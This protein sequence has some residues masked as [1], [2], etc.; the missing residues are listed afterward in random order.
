MVP[1]VSVRYF[2]DQVGPAVTESHPLTVEHVHLSASH[3]VFG[4]QEVK[5][6]RDAAQEE[7]D[8]R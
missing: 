7:V 5:E 3:P 1:I 8:E 6:I 2:D 4:D